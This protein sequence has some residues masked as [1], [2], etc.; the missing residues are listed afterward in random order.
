MT[1]SRREEPAR[2]AVYYSVSGATL[3]GTYDSRIDWRERVLRRIHN[4]QV[5]RDG[6]LRFQGRRYRVGVRF[7]RQR[8]EL[9][10]HGGELRVYLPGNKAKA[11]RLARTYR[12]HQ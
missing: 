6:T 2:E 10:R 11:F 12:R 8:L 4:R 1:W 9:L 7:A 3:L 5:K